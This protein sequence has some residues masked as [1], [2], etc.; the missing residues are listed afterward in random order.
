MQQE[1]KHSC[2]VLEDVI[3]GHSLQL[4]L[5][6]LEECTLHCFFTACFLLILRLSEGAGGFMRCLVWYLK[7]L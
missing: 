2:Q 7:L 1:E 3:V 5:G 4:S 6:T